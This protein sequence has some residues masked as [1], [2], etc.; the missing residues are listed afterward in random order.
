MVTAKIFEF[1]NQPQ[2][3]TGFTRHVLNELSAMLVQYHHEG[4]LLFKVKVIVTELLNNAIKHSGTQKSKIELHLDSSELI[5]TKSDCGKPFDLNNELQKRNGQ[6]VLSSDAM[7]L[8]YAVKED[9]AK[10]RF[11]CEENLS[12]AID[13]N[14]LAEHMGLLII[15]KAAQEFTYEYLE[16]VNLF[17]VK[18]TLG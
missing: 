11:Y 5:I 8:L 4:D 10:V 13:F 1:D 7:H 12:D 18:I 9:E 15:T 3:L 14:A 6:V 17:K 16:P 2:N